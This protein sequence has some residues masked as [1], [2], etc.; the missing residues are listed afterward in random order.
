MRLLA[1]VWVAGVLPTVTTGNAIADE[2]WYHLTRNGC[3]QPP[4]D[5]DDMER[6][7]ATFILTL[8]ALGRDYS[9]EDKRDPT[10]QIVASVITD[11][12]TGG[13]MT[14]FRVEANCKTVFEDM[15]SQQKK[16]KTI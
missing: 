16:S 9:V 8:K 1:P 2:G 11:H 10:G 7:P 15:Q 14:F 13:T 12:S 6:S 5:P 4:K 3:L